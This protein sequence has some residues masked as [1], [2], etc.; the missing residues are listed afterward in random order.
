M[1]LFGFDLLKRDSSYTDALV[2]AITANASGKSTAFPTATAALEACA[3][4]I[5]RAFATATVDSTPAIQASLT[6]A[7]LALV[8]RAL[9][10]RGELICYVDPKDFDILPCSSHDISGSPLP[11]SWRYRCVTSGPS[12]TRTYRAVPRHGVLHFTYSVDIST[13]W[14]GEGPLQVAQLAGRLSAETA[15]ALADESAGPRGAFLPLPVDGADSTVSALKADIRNARGNMLVTE[16][17]DYDNVGAGRVAD[18]KSMRFGA[19]PP[20]GLVETMSIASREI[21]AA[22]GVNPSLFSSDA[23]SAGRE[24]YRQLLFGT[25][26]PLGMMVAAELTE[27]LETPVKLDW[28]ELRASDIASRAR[29]F[30]SL[31]GSGMDTDKAAALSGLLMDSE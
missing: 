8:G 12:R 20:A 27:K 9:I 4:M 2:A 29:A 13:P 28:T 22:C 11:T 15:A 3:G 19:N 10:R 30:Q 5:G 1:K 24:A 25:V 21:F 16:G 26:A 23:G 14:R 7:F 18:Y 6:P 31:V 17:G